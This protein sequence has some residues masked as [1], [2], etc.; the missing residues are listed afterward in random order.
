MHSP[1]QNLREESATLMPWLLA[2]CDQSE[3]ILKEGSHG[4]L[5][6][7]LEALSTLPQSSNYF[8]GGTAAP[9]HGQQAED[10]HSLSE[11]LAK[12]HPWRKGPLNIGGIH[13]D[14]EWRSDWKWDRIA[15][16]LNL[17]GHRILDI[18]CGNGYYGWR[19][20]DRGALSVIGIDPTLVYAMQ[21]LACRHFSGQ[22]PNYVLPLSLEDLPSGAGGFDT[23][24][25]MGVLYH[26][27]DPASH[28][29]RLASLLK[30]GGQ[31]LL[32]T[33]VI[34]GDGNE[35]LVPEHRYARMRNVWSIPTVSRLENLISESGFETSRVLDVSPTSTEEQRT[36]QWMRFESLAQSLDPKDSSKTIEGH[37]A[38]IRV[39]LLARLPGG[40]LFC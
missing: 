31:L 33:L 10:G 12:L 36:T 1:Y 40:K 20:L 7:W 16:H 27:R 26:R 24:F 4:D 28:L 38:P 8:D 6:G 18:G 29:R 21:W 34:G 39:A 3:A 30:P 13:I 37:P 9:V 2:L 14:T 11:Q 19:M 23:V 17:D 32:E 35:E 22:V 5:P 25:S 15:Q